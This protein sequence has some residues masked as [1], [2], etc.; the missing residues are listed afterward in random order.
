MLGP[1]WDALDSFVPGLRDFIV[2]SVP[3]GCRLIGLDERT[4]L[5]GDG[6]DWSVVG[7]GAAHLYLDGEW[8]HHGAG[9]EFELDLIG[10]TARA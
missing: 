5:L 10:S 2:R 8:D 9:S 6:Q 1:H 7:S 3:P 4:A